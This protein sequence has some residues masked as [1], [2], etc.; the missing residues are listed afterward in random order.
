MT[1]STETKPTAG[2]VEAAAKANTDNNNGQNENATEA[3]KATAAAAGRAEQ[4]KSTADIVEDNPKV[5]GEE[6]GKA[7]DKKLP[8]E[9]QANFANITAD[10]QHAVE[11]KGKPL[12]KAAKTEGRQIELGD[13]VMITTATP[14][15]GQ[16][17]NEAH[18]IGFNATSGNP[19][20][21]L[22]LSDGGRSRATE[23]GNVPQNA[24]HEER[25][26]F[27]QFP[28]AFEKK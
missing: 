2:T 3:D 16:T 13:R 24:A 1:K 25:G 7:G 15:G 9:R 11:N 27:W 20:L 6:E 26:P 19:N 8:L 28:E 18:V 17:V 22:A 10:Q 12:N 5:F 14:I 4:G 23:F 21:R